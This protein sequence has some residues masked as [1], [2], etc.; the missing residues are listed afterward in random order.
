MRDL[1]VDHQWPSPRI[2]DDD[3]VIHGE[4]VGGERLDVPFPD[5]HRVPER[6]IQTHGG[7]ARD[8][9]FRAAVHPLAGLAVAEEGG[10]GPEVGDDPGADEHVARQAFVVL[11]QV[12]DVFGP[13]VL[14]A[15]Q[16]RDQLLGANQLLLTHLLHEVCVC[17]GGWWWW[18]W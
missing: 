7:R 4:R 8:L 16:T 1:R 5:Q 2:E 17:V 6:D 3:A 14:L 11:A 13:A 9:E 10:E 12:F 18:W 15:A